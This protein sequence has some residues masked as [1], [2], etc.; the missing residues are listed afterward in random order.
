MGRLTEFTLGRRSHSK[1]KGIINDTLARPDLFVNLM[2]A[3][4]NR[5]KNLADSLQRDIQATV[6]AHL[7]VIRFTLDITRSENVASESEKNPE[8]RGAVDAE[9]AV[10]REAIQRIQEVAC[11]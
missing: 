7:E 4:R 6:E 3:F 10:A 11:L 8:F 5:F 1:R 9:I 2:K